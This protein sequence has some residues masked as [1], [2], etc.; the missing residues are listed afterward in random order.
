MIYI[1]Y[2][3]CSQYIIYFHE[4]ILNQIAS[5]RTYII[6]TYSMV[7][8]V[9]PSLM[10]KRRKK[11][12]SSATT[13]FQTAGTRYEWYWRSEIWIT[14]KGFKLND[15]VLLIWFLIF[16]SNVIKRFGDHI[17]GGTPV[18]IPN[19]VVKTNRADDTGA[20]ALGK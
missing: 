13:R 5:D 17:V 9:I 3:A 1:L 12:T 15:N 6:P 18:P 7:R 16:C 19:T 4:F 10:A 11:S 14:F 20:C 8:M 2:T